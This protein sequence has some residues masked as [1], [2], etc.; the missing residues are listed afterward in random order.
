MSPIL[1][2]HPPFSQDAP[3]PIFIT[4]R[5][6][7]K[8]LKGTRKSIPFAMAMVWP[9]PRRHL[10]AV[11][12]V[13]HNESLPIPVASKTYTL[14][15]ETDLEDFET[16]PGPPTSTDDDEKYPAD[17]VYRQ[18]HLVTEP[19]LNDLV[20]DLE[21]PKSKSQLLGSRLQQ[22]TLKLL[23]SEDEGL[24]FCPNS[25]ELMVELKMPCDPHKRSLKVVPLAN[26]NDLLS[27]PVAYSVDMK[28]TY[29][30]ISRI[31]DKI[32]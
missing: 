26:E 20:R 24:V 6:L 23:F 12:P 21:L 11:R 10:T 32:C 25:K 5:C 13:P 2:H 29:E 14:Q 16:Q 4:V 8:W 30:N 15:L 7:T 19:E 1:P 22:S 28:E 17:L 3:P 18:L 27:V 31:L 9:E